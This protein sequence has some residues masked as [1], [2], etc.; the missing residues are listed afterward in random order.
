MK[1]HTTNESSS[2]SEE[3]TERGLLLWQSGLV[4][5]TSEVGA[6][7]VHSSCKARDYHASTPWAKAGPSCTC[8]D[9]EY[10]HTIC[11]HIIAASLEHAGHL[12]RG[13][14]AKGE[15]LRA[16]EE[17]LLTIG[18]AGVPS[19]HEIAWQSYWTAT[20]QL[21]EKHRRSQALPAL[22][23]LRCGEGAMR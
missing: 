15:T 21:L 3:R 13:R 19:E 4:S 14:I 17:R 18:C 8:P 2:P 12:I 5:P 23:G 22:G 9:F 7:F 16:I 10:R 11:K 20:Q 1:E 6:Y